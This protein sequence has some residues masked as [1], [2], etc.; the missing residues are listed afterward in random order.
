MLRMTPRTSSR[1][2][3]AGVVGLAFSFIGC[4]ERSVRPALA[5]ATPL[6]P[7]GTYI[8]LQAGWRLSVITPLFKSGKFVLD[9]VDGQE[10][11]SES[12]GGLSLSIKAGT[13][14]LGY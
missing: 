6:S 3:L 7:A 1:L 10:Q 12:S 4:A 14:F 8:D 11:S 5:A 9:S 2:R 13:D